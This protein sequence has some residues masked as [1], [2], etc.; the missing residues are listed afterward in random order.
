MAMD[1]N[2]Y[3]LNAQVATLLT[4]VRFMREDITELKTALRTELPSLTARV[5]SLETENK[6]WRARFSVAATLATLL[7]GGVA[8]VCEHILFK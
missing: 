8:W 6:L 2:A 4:E 7:G 1:A 3:A 5:T